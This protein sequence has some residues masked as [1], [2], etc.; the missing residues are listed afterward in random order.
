MSIDFE[1]AETQKL[2]LSPTLDP[3]L[4]NKYLDQSYNNDTRK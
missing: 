2:W 1:R 3:P 4:R